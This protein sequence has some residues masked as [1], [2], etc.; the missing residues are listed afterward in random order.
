MS[1]RQQSEQ[2]LKRLQEKIKDVQALQAEAKEE[3]RVEQSRQRDAMRDLELKLNDAVRNERILEERCNYLAQERTRIEVQA[4][5]RYNREHE[6]NRE[7][8]RSMEA[9]VRSLETQLKQR[10][11]DSF[12]KSTEYDKLQALIDQKLQLTE[13]ELAE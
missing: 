10:E 11:Q 13:R 2:N 6:T 3:H 5:E 4:T 8:V 9:K 7:A 12:K 1:V